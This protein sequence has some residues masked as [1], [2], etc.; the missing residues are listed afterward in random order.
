MKNKEIMRKLKDSAFNILMFLGIAIVIYSYIYT[1]NGKEES[2]I[3]IQNVTGDQDKQIFTNITDI[4]IEK[5]MDIKLNISSATDEDKKL[6]S[7][8]KESKDIFIKD[9]EDVE[10]A[11]KDGSF[12]SLET[13]GTKI[14]KDGQNYLNTANNVGISSQFNVLLDEY[15]KSLESYNKAGRLIESGS[16]S[17]QSPNL[18][19]SIDYIKEGRRHMDMTINLIS[20]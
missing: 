5:N 20:G 4:D 10:K 3:E 17:H 7:I 6:V 19:N 1:N 14:R 8:I 2:H 15:K 16:R 18:M 11:A 12:K 13:A 9:I